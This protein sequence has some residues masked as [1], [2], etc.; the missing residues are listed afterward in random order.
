MQLTHYKPNTILVPFIKGY[1]LLQ[2]I[3][4]STSVTST[5]FP[6]G[7]VEIIFHL[8]TPFLRQQ[9]DG[10]VTEKCMFI[11]G[12][13]TG[14][15]TIKQKGPIKSVGITLHP[16]AVSFFYNKQPSIFTDN[17][18]DAGAL[19]SLLIN[20]YYA[21]LEQCN[22]ESIPSICDSYFI[23]LIGKKQGLQTAAD[24]HFINLINC[25]SQ[26]GTIKELKKEW[27]FSPRYFEQKCFQLLGIS[28][29]DLVKK[30]RMKKAL[31][32]CLQK[33]FCSFTD[34]AHSCGYYDQSHFNKDFNFYFRQSPRQVFKHKDFFLQSFL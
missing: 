6:V 3:E 2:D 25:P 15:I 27:S 4:P 32:K 1:W 19:D 26:E 23:N 20:L 7:A 14:A 31:N 5:L 13:Q 9:L 16:W 29:V 10:W 18:F 17:R 34:V 33:D 22:A 24:R 8:Q 11:E 28:A 30:R 21:L 12:Q